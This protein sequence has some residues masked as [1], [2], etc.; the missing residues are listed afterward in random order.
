MDENCNA[1]TLSIPSPKA[2]GRLSPVI[3]ARDAWWVLRGRDLA[4]QGRTVAGTSVIKPRR[5]PFVTKITGNFCAILCST[6]A[7][8]WR[9]TTDAFGNSKVP[10]QKQI[11]KFALKFKLA[12]MIMTKVRLSMEWIKRFFYIW[13]LYFLLFFSIWKI[14]RRCWTKPAFRI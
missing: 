6:S 8:R 2:H 3:F 11:R 7:H 13:Y 1:K 9:P 4:C 12:I 14:N 5:A 10:I